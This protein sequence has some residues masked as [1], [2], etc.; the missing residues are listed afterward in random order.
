M[1]WNKN[2]KNRYTPAYPS[3]A[4]EKWG[5]RGY[6][7]HGHIFLICSAK[8]AQ[9]QKRGFRFYDQGKFEQM[10]SRLRTKVSFLCNITRKNP[11]LH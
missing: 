2:K 5:I 10:G 4:I 11:C 3:F 9:R 1:F 8:G 6:T 7:F